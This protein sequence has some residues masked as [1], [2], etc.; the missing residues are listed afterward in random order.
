[1]NQKHHR[2]VDEWFVGVRSGEGTGN[3]GIQ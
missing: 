1:M 3:C 2:T